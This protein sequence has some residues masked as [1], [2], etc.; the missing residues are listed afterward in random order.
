MSDNWEKGDLAMC[1]IGGHSLNP[2]NCLHAR[3]YPQPGTIH[4]VE[5][6]E[7]G[8]DHNGKLALWLGAHSLP[9]NV[10]G[11]RVWG[12]IR[13]RKVTAPEAD[14]FDREVIELMTKQPVEV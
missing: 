1:V 14:E 8:L 5:I 7:S 6:I 4:I 11:G 10:V 2:P 13:F 3:E 12:A 9:E